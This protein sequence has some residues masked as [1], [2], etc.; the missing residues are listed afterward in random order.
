MFGEETFSFIDSDLH[1]KLWCFDVGLMQSFVW[2]SCLCIYYLELVPHRKGGD[3]PAFSFAIKPSRS[4]SL[5]TSCGACGK[6][7]GKSIFLPRP[8]RWLGLRAHSSRAAGSL[9]SAC[10]LKWAEIYG[11]S[12][13][14]WHLNQAWTRAARLICSPTCRHSYKQLQCQRFRLCSTIWQAVRWEASIIY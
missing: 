13:F 7:P 5:S 11:S 8:S 9:G 3:S 14:M 4:F 2:K 12:L 10:F 6:T 1:T